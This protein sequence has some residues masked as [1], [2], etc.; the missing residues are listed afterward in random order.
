M[1]PFLYLMRQVTQS[2]VALMQSS[3]QKAPQLLQ[4]TIAF[5]LHDTELRPVCAMLGGFGNSG[6]P[7]DFN[8]ILFPLFGFGFKRT[9]V[10]VVVARVVVIIFFGTILMVGEGAGWGCCGG[11]W[12]GWT[13][14]A[15]S[16]CSSATSAAD[17]VGEVSTLAGLAGGGGGAWPGGGAE[18]ALTGT[19]PPT[20]SP[21]RRLDAGIAMS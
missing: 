5:M 19:P 20:I 2:L 8:I 7:Y 11:G 9:L 12:V 13:G 3:W 4:T 16:S 17:L 10:V 14:L 21:A 15:I 1:S 6:T 18:E